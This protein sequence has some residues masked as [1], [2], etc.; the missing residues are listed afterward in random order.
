MFYFLNKTIPFQLFLDSVLITC[1]INK[2]HSIVLMWRHKTIP[3]QLFLNFVFITYG[4]NKMHSIVLM[5]R[6]ITLLSTKS[7]I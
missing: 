7:T 2:M 5:W 3:F 6:H 1:G 4:I